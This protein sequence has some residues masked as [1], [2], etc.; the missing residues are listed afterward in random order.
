ML[1]SYV[2]FYKFSHTVWE[3]MLLDIEE[4]HKTID[5]EQYIFVH[6][7]EIGKRFIAA[8]RRKNAQGVKI[9]LLC[10][11]V[12]SYYFYRSSLPDELRKEGIEV[13]FFNPIQP[14][15]IRNFT[16]HF[17]RNHR[18][19][20][21]VDNAVG[22]LGG[23]NVGSYMKDWRDTH[24]RIIGPTVQDIEATFEGVWK[25]IYKSILFQFRDLKRTPKEYEILT[26]AAGFRQRFIYRALISKIKAAQK[27]IYLTTPYFIPDARLMRVLKKAVKRGVD[28]RIILPGDRDPSFI[29]YAVQSYFSIALKAGIKVYTYRDVMMHA[30]TAVIDSTWATVGSYNLDNISEYFNREVNLASSNQEFVDKLLEHTEEDF[31]HSKEVDYDVWK[32]RPFYQKI[33]EYVIMPLHGIF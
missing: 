26:N 32:K 7:D 33:I 11:M 1:E 29:H 19:T 22:Y 6:D 27:Y 13:R 10:D 2:T 3:A 28:V 14:W 15:R 21:V 4:A 31:K 9:R 25:N 12:G 24:V 18:K 20:M 8:F 5:F 16:S 23:I 30:K 17:F